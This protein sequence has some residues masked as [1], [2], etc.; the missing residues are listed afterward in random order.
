MAEGSV[1]S[2]PN[3]P[4]LGAA[5]YPEDWP[6]EQIDE[7]IELM[8]QA[9]INCIRIAEFAWS[10]MEPREG[11]YDFSWLHTA[12]D[13]LAEAGIA[14]IM[15]TP[16]ATPPAW[17]SCKHPDIL[18]VSPDG[19]TID[20]GGRRHYDPCSSVYKEYTKRIVTRLAQEFGQDNRIIGWQID[21]ELFP[22][23]TPSDFTAPNTEEARAGFAGFLRKRYGTIDELNKTWCTSL[24]SQTYSSF[25]QVPY[26]NPQVWHHP[27]LKTTWR[28][29]IE[30]AYIDYADLQAEILH[31]LARQPVGTNMMSLPGLDHYKTNR[32]LDVVQ[33]DRYHFGDDLWQVPYWLDRIRPIKSRPFWVVETAACWSGSTASGTYSE[34]GFCMANSWLSIALGGEMNSYWLWRQHWAGQELMHGGVIQSNGRPMHIF[35]EVKE[36]ARGFTTCAEFINGTCPDITGLAIHHSTLAYHMFREQP[37]TFG[38]DYELFLADRIYRP[39]IQEQWRPDFIH[40]GMDLSPYKLIISPFLPALDEMG[41]RNRLLDWIKDGGTWIAG[42]YTDVRDLHGSKFR[43]SAY[44]SLEEWGAVYAKYQIPSATREFE[45]KWADGTKSKGSLVFDGLKLRGAE[46]LADYTEYPFE[47]LAAISKRKL[48][49][50]QVIVLGTLLKPADLVKLTSMV[51][52]GLG[53]NSAAK[54]SA[55][56]IVVPR[57]GAAGRGLIAVEIENRPAELMLNEIATDILTGETLSGTV[58]IP[59]Y[60]V[61]VLRYEE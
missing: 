11:E 48:G 4:Y 1:R 40:P 37:M 33:F 46:A 16:T 30:Q 61:R 13:K 47:G 18:Y 20:H 60:G 53:V 58:S 14:I 38:F 42:P 50:G 45:F 10:T 31:Q 36:I 34:R 55:N 17:L 3:P 8:K 7:D 24:W 52:P 59:P 56:L 39:L 19:R 35:G 44:G 43:H 25:E 9:G 26:P 51:A 6:L 5:Y 28:E 15:C 29:F 41:L 23:S 49:K 2:I 57:S 12:V 54:A 22:Y 21:N 32:K 27:A